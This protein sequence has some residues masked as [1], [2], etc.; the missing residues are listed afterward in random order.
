MMIFL[1][2]TKKKRNVTGDNNIIKPM[3][4]RNTMGAS[5]VTKPQ[6]VNPQMM[7]IISQNSVFLID[8][9][10]NSKVSCS[11]ILVTLILE[12]SGRFIRV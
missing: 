10:V 9:F 3:G 6:K 7:V 11:S 1:L 12:F 5:L 8:L 2:P 4:I